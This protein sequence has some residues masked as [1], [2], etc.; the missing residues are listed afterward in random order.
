MTGDRTLL[1]T[2]IDTDMFIGMMNPWA[3]SF[4]SSDTDQCRP[5]SSL[6]CCPCIEGREGVC[7][8][9]RGD[10]V[11]GCNAVSGWVCWLL[12]KCR[13]RLSK[14]RILTMMETETDSVCTTTATF[15]SSVVAQ[16]PLPRH[17]L[18]LLSSST[19]LFIQRSFSRDVLFLF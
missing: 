13:T 8:S 2:R 18:F 7:C 12:G 15:T 1:Y 6:H 14:T 17:L 5:Y 11:S 3:Y 10:A 19:K 9:F 4:Y 16:D